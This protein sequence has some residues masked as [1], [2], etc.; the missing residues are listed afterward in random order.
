MGKAWVLVAV[1]SAAIVGEG[2]ALNRPEPLYDRVGGEMMISAIVDDFINNAMGD[3][4]VN[5]TRAGTSAEWQA[6]PENVEMVR[7]HL[8]EFIEAAAGGPQ[9]YEGKDMKAAHAGMQITDAQF[10]AAEQ[11]FKRSLEKYQVGV[12]ETNELMGIIEGTRKDIV[13]Q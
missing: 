9:E 10:N 6:T 12:N 3:P 5:F 8:V 11:D 1:L 7:G 4:R 2:C 13:G